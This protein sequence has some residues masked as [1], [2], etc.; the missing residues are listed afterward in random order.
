[1]TL[2]SSAASYNVHGKVPAEA[3]TEGA[4]IT[5]PA[6]GAKFSTSTQTVSGTCPDNSY[7]KL[8]VN[9]TFAGVAW[10]SSNAF[11]IQVSLHSGQNDLRAQ[12]Y[13]V[14][15][16]PGPATPVVSVTFTP[17]PPPPSPP[18]PPNTVTGS[19]GTPIGLQ[20]NNG[21]YSLHGNSGSGA[22]LL[23]TSDFHYQTF[24]TGSTFRW[25]IDLEGGKAPYNVKINWGDGQQSSLI[26]KQSKQFWIEHTYTEGGYYKILVKSV[27]ANGTSRI[28]QLAALIKKAG[29]ASIFSLHKLGIGSS[30]T[31]SGESWWHNWLILAW[32]L[33]LILILMAFSFWLG[34]RQEYSKL[35]NRLVAKKR[36]SHR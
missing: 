2:K 4:T 17:P 24:T 32:P 13:N 3:L 8:Y 28:V 9:N 30:S 11:Q 12:D 23:L 6:D 29:A 31:S 16:D 14:T 21:S 25:S 7:V 34:E 27:D 19:A 15:D 20:D 10:C 33:W 36:Y 22:P 35:K 1:M 18:P 26:I 5:S